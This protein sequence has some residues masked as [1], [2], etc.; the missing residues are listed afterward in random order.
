MKLEVGM[1]VRT[2]WGK[3]GKITGI[4]KSFD[5]TNLIAGGFKVEDY[6]DVVCEPIYIVDTNYNFDDEPDGYRKEDII[7]ASHELLGNDK[8][9]CLIEVGDYVNGERVVEIE[10]DGWISFSNNTFH[11][12]NFVD[13]IVTKEQFENISYK[14]EREENENDTK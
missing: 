1:Y 5:V 6:G 2:K 13:S 14:L 3:I 4:E 8:E 7:K 11:K 12:C 10:K 9:P